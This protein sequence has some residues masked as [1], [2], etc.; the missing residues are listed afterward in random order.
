ML[1]EILIKMDN[2]IRNLENMVYNSKSKPFN[3]KEAADYLNISTNFLYKLTSKKEI[4]Y[5]KPTGKIIYFNKRELDEWI[6]KNK[7]SK[8]SN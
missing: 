8:E 2:R 3:L 5:Y 1:K 7:A 6:Y 4:P